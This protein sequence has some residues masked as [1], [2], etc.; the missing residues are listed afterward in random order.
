MNDIDK[1]K[2]FVYDLITISERK[3]KELMDIQ[4]QIHDLNAQIIAL[5]KKEDNNQKDK[6]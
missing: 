1:L 5:S 4:R 3:Q 6:K 2:V